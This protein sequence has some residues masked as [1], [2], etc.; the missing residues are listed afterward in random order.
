MELISS[1]CPQHYDIIYVQVQRTKQEFSVSD[2]CS[3]LRHWV[4]RFYSE[5]VLS[6]AQS[7]ALRELEG[8]T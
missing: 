5:D 8:M 4:I 3:D 1:R 2:F 7:F 6:K